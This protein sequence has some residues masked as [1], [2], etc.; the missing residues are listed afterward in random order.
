V[1]NLSKADQIFSLIPKCGNFVSHICNFAKQRYTP[2]E[3][4][5]RKH[6]KNLQTWPCP[7]SENAAFFL[8]FQTAGWNFA[9]LNTGAS[10]S[11]CGKSLK[12]EMTMPSYEYRCQD[13]GHEFIEV[14]RVSEH[15]K[16]KPRCPKCKSEKI[17]Q[18]LSA[19]FAKTSRKA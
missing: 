19:F 7:F 5:W 13:C 9:A 6:L 14:L 11:V 17:E 1:N 10:E 12:G 2:T 16:Q 3:K 4:V 18:K 8:R 15:D